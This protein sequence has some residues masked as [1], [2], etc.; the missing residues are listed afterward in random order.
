M[1]DPSK[2]G[3]VFRLGEEVDSPSGACQRK[4]PEYRVPMP[5]AVMPIAIKAAA[6]MIAPESARMNASSESRAGWAAAR[7]GL[8]TKLSGTAGHDE[9]DARQDHEET[10]TTATSPR[11]ILSLWAVK[12]A[13]AEQRS[14]AAHAHDT[15]SVKGS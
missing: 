12:A 3:V 9:Q 8:K 15:F 10:T 11:P 6:V 2:S 13:A 7:R 5:S 14:T 1:R 4:C